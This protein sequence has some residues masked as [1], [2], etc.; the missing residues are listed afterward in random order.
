M[1]SDVKLMQAFFDSADAA[2]YIKDEKGRLLL[3]NRKA[4][5]KLNCSEAECVGKS[6]YDFLP[7]EQAEHVISKDRQVTETGAPVDYEITLDLPGGKRTVH[8]HKFAIS[9]PGHPGAIAGIAVEV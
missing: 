9:I 2:F 4:A 8:D 5:E 7:K 3:V 1:M 6:D